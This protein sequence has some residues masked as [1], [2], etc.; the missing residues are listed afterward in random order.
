MRQE[1][2]KIINR[3]L[4]KNKGSWETQPESPYFNLRRLYEIKG[5]QDEFHEGVCWE[6]AKTK[7]GG[8]ESLR[9]GV[10]GLRIERTGSQDWPSSFYHFPRSKIGGIES[11]AHQSSSIV[12][13][14]ISEDG[15]QTFA[16]ALEAMIPVLGAVLSAFNGNPPFSLA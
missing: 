13:H 4:K 7:A 8:E 11:F 10:A 15:M 3:F 2:T 6:E 1:E 5:Y 14:A 16:L 9:E 12:K